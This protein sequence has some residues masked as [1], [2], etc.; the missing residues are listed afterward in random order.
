MH[1]IRTPGDF[2]MALETTA[3]KVSLARH[4]RHPELRE[5]VEKQLSD[6]DELLD[7]YKRQIMLG[8]P[9]AYYRQVAAKYGHNSPEA[10]AK[11]LDAIHRM[12]ASDPLVLEPSRKD[13]HSEFL[14]VFSGASY[15]MAKW[16]A[17]L[18][19]SHLITD[20]EA[21]WAEI[22]VDRQDAG[23]KD[24]IW[25]PFAKAFTN[26][27]FNY[28]NDVPVDVAL[29]LR[30]EDRL[31]DLRNCL[32][33][34]WRACRGSDEFTAANADALA[35]ELTDQIRLAEAEWE[36]IKGSLTKQAVIM[37][38]PQADSRFPVPQGRQLTQ[39]RGGVSVRDGRTET[40]VPAEHTSV[41]F[42]D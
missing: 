16:T 23:V 33:R 15:E 26:V 12:R 27:P 40:T 32:G 4:E 10:V 28:L 31:G 1:F 3:E 41:V 13:S 7:S 36:E 42:R 37:H 9:D 24:D 17:A 30:K 25:T 14:Q 29:R 35:L 18:S 6:S 22:Q 5:L 39:V 8:M 20:I 21:R 11:F 34:A 38:L 2:D 19:G